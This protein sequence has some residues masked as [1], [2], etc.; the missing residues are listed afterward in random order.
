MSDPKPIKKKGKLARYA[1][2]AGGALALIGAGGAG[3]AYAVSVGMVGASH[4]AEASANAVPETV[5]YYAIEQGF[6]ANLRDSSSFVQA[7]VA[8]SGKGEKLIEAVKANE[9]AM[10]S[11]V[12]QLLADQDYATI[13]TP[14]GR[15]A[16]QAKLRGALDA[17]LR[18][19]VGFG[20]IDNVYFTAFVLQ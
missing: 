1:V 13:S 14:P 11:V 5:H 17:E 4:A 8:V 3:G 6:T 20:G 15:K 9:P 7:S 16:L 18:A 10:R 2:P 19:K 12:L